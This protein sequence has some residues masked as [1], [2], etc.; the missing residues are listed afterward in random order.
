MAE[1]PYAQE[2]SNAEKGFV[3]TEVKVTKIWY[4]DN[5]FTNTS[6]PPHIIAFT[7]PV[8]SKGPAP[9]KSG[10]PWEPG[11]KYKIEIKMIYLDAQGMQQTTDANTT[12]VAPN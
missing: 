1:I 9:S 6:I 5:K 12:V 11:K 3:S 7:P 10:F 8:P 2:L 4:V